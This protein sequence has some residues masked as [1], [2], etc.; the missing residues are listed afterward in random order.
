[1][2]FANSVYYYLILIH[3]KYNYGMNKK[4]SLILTYILKL[5]F[6][7]NF[8]LKNISKKNINIKSKNILS[9]I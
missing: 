8:K 5:F 9:N 4:W 7:E 1:M 2:Q 6:I 3:I